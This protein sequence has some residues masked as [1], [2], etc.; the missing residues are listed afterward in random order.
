MGDSLEELSLFVEQHDVNALI[1]LLCSTPSLCSLE[2]RTT[3]CFNVGALCQSVL[4]DEHWLLTHLNTLKFR[5]TNGVDFT[6]AFV[7]MIWVQRMGNNAVPVLHKV[8]VYFSDIVEGSMSEDVGKGI[9]EFVKQGVV[10]L[11]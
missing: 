2:I 5:G 10:E 8:T 11:L 6:E 9:N 3:T 4:V 7:D 1:A